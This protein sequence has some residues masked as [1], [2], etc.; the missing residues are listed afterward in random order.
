MNT[1]V[2][3]LGANESTCGYCHSKQETSHSFGMWGHAMSAMDYQRLIDRGWRRSG[4]YLYKPNLGSSCCQAYTIRMDTTQFALSKG[5][6]KVLKKMSKYLHNNV[7]KPESVKPLVSTGSDVDMV[8]EMPQMPVVQDLDIQM[9]QCTHHTVSKPLLKSTPISDTIR[10][11]EE[12]TNIQLQ[13]KLR[14]ELVKSVFDPTVFELYR[15]YQ[16]F[17]HKDPPEKLKESQFTGFL[18]DSPIAFEPAQ[19][20]SAFGYGSFHQKYYIDDKL[21]AVS[22]IDILPY[23]VSGV[24]FFYDPDYSFLSLGNYSALREITLVNRLNMEAPQLKYYYM[25]FYIHSCVKMR[26][27]GQYKPSFLLCPLTYHWIP[28]TEALVLI[29]QEPRTALATQ[30]GQILQQPLPLVLN[31]RPQVTKTFPPY[32]WIKGQVQRIQVIDLTL[33]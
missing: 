9:P 12:P 6:K 14:F 2:Q 13:H 8:S 4:K 33:V 25:G 23:C 7:G 1:I 11:I 10:E 31:K 3:L 19:L 21:V 28:I 22:V 18:V 29:E 16:M 15:K 27:K 26:Y 5:Q 24:Y 32:I 17:V 20:G 30:E